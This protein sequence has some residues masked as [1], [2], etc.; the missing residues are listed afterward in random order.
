[1]GN[2]VDGAAQD[3]AIGMPVT[4]TWVERIA[5]DATKVLLPQWQR[6]KERP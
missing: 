3:V 1:V 2:L 4:A 5:E 6:V